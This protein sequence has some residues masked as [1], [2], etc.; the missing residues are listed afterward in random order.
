[1]LRAVSDDSATAV[2]QKRRRIVVMPN[3]P[4]LAEFVQTIPDLALSQCCSPSELASTNACMG[5]QA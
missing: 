1:M 2:R 3:L 5:R 4:A